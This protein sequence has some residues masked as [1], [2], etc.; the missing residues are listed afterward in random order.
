MQ[1]QHFSLQVVQEVLRLCSM[2]SQF[3]KAREVARAVRVKLELSFSP[4]A[5]ERLREL[6]GALQR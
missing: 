3:D 4:D 2:S 6:E 5:S 1:A